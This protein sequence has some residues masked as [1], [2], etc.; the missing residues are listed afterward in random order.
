MRHICYIIVLITISMAQY[1]KFKNEDSIREFPHHEKASFSVS[2]YL[3]CSGRRT[4]V[5]GGRA[6]RCA[7]SNL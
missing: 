1:H 5:P 2:R 4:A 7:L 3:H 6:V